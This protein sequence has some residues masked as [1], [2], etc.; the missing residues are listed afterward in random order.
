VWVVSHAAN[1]WKTNGSNAEDRKMIAKL[2]R[3]KLNRKD[4][5]GND[6]PSLFDDL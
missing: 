5:A 3:P 1:T 6:Q 2:T 4:S